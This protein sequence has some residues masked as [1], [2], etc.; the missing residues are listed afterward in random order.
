MA[1]VAGPMRIAARHC[2]TSTARVIQNMQACAVSL[3]PGPR[4]KPR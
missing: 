4:A 2:I 1:P 3:L